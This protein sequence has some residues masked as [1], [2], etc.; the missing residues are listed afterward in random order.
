MKKSSSKDS[1]ES[2]TKQKYKN[3]AVKKGDKNNVNNE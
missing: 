2:Y 3:K 1:S